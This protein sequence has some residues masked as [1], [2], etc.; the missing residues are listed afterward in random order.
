MIKHIPF[1]ITGLFIAGG[2]LWFYFNVI[3]ESP[4]AKATRV[5]EQANTAFENGNL[6]ALKAQLDILGEPQ[7]REQET[8]QSLIKILIQTLERSGSAKV[9]HTYD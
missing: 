6:V 4:I 3:K 9:T 7:C 1:I 2:A 5:L 8:T